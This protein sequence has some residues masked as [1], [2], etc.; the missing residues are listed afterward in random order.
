MSVSRLTAM[1]NMFVWEGNTGKTA[2]RNIMMKQK[3]N[4]QKEERKSGRKGKGTKM[5]KAVWTSSQFPEVLLW[6]W[7]KSHAQ[8]QV[9]YDSVKSF[10]LI[11]H[12]E[13][14]CYRVL[15]LRTCGIPPCIAS[16][17][18]IGK[19]KLKSALNPNESARQFWLYDKTL[20]CSKTIKS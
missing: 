4:R 8:I 2:E 18:S 6:V 17:K 12:S 19:I 3:K 10:L 1:G 11:P 13:L 16:R 9:I 7:I 20:N 14:F 15:S 5:K